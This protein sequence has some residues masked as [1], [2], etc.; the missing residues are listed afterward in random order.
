MC[1]QNGSIETDSA[2]KFLGLTHQSVIGWR[3]CH[4]DEFFRFIII[5]TMIGA[6]LIALAM[7]ITLGTP[8]RIIAKETPLFAKVQVGGYISL[9]LLCFLG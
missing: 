4:L 6:P 8:L 9:H 2:E 5:L 7:V 1:L 3:W